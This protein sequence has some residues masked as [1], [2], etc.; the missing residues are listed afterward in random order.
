M[1][2]RQ[3]ATAASA[4]SLASKSRLRQ[5]ERESCVLTRPTLLEMTHYLSRATFRRSTWYPGQLWLPLPTFPRFDLPLCLFPDRF[6][7][8]PTAPQVAADT[9]QVVDLL[10]AQIGEAFSTRRMGMQGRGCEHVSRRSRLSAPIEFI[11]ESIPDILG[12][13]RTRLIRVRLLWWPANL[14]RHGRSVE[15]SAASGPAFDRQ[16]HATAGE[17]HR[18][19]QSR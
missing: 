3:R 2:S 18:R 8:I 14:I 7:D 10:S 9:R 15:L 11:N 6:D 1:T 4:G 12:M 19:R 17:R 13:R 16:R 5:P